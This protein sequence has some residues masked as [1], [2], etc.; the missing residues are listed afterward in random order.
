L[1]ISFDAFTLALKTIVGRP[2]A[3]RRHRET[4]LLIDSSDSAILKENSFLFIYLTFKKKKIKL[5][6]KRERESLRK[7]NGKWNM[8]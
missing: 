3:W 8:V 4:A 1:A 7:K 5:R 2:F 6:E